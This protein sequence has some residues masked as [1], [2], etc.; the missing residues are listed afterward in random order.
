MIN[1]SAPLR[2]FRA[3]PAGQR[4]AQSGGG[5]FFSYN[6]HLAAR[7]PHPLGARGKSQSCEDHNCRVRSLEQRPISQGTLA[8]THARFACEDRINE[9]IFILRW[10]VFSLS[11]AVKN[12]PWTTVALGDGPGKRFAEWGGWNAA[13]GTDKCDGCR[14]TPAV[15]PTSGR[16]ASES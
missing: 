16:G 6:H 2:I 8:L 4:I 3:V 5:E 1:L 9:F 11:H 7:Q 13:Q 12:R 14:R 15:M 10:R